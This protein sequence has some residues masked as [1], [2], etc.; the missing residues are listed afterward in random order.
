MFSTSWTRL[1]VGRNGGQYEP[2]GSGSCCSASL[3]VGIEMGPS[4]GGHQVI[5][6][7]RCKMRLEL[8]RVFKLSKRD[9]LR[10]VQAVV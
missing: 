4:S 5:E 9:L 3:S 10:L 8:W 6:R 2:I 7:R 1:S